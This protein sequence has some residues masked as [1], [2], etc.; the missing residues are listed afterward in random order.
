MGTQLQFSM[1]SNYVLAGCHSFYC[2]IRST[3][4]LCVG[5]DLESNFGERCY[6]GHDDLDDTD[7]ARLVS[8]CSKSEEKLSQQ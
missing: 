6:C 1:T 2:V 3:I 4:Q 5:R 8:N 7:G